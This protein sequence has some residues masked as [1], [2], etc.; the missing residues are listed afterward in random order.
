[1]RQSVN[2]LWHCQGDQWL[3]IALAVLVAGV[4][5]LGPGAWSVEA[6]LFGR[7]RFEFTRRN[8]PDAYH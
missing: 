3:H 8:R 7:K 1:V 5:M 4:A 6:R 2:L